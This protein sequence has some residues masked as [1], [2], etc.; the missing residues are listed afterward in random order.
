[1][2][3]AP[4]AQQFLARLDALRSGEELAKIQRYF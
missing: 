4:N 3:D 2:S 1:M